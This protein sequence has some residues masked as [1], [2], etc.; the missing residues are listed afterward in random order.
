MGQ[1][2][3]ARDHK[4]RQMDLFLHGGDVFVGPTKEQSIGE[5]YRALRV[6]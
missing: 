2:C 1:G 5:N 6:G 4:V 3:G